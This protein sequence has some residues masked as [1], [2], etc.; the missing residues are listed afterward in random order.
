MDGASIL[1]VEDEAISALYIKNILTRLKYLVLDIVATGEN[2]IAKA[3]ALNPD[4]I[5]MDIRLAGEMDGIQAADI[6]HS[7]YDIPIVFLT[8]HLDEDSMRQAMATDPA[9]YVPKPTSERELRGTIEMALKNDVLKKQLRASEARYRRIFKTASVSISEIDFSQVKCALDGLRHEGITDLHAYMETN[10]NYIHRLFLYV[11]ILDA[12]D[13]NLQLF[14]A[15]DGKTLSSALKKLV[16]SES[17]LIFQELLHAIWKGDSYYEGEGTI[18]TL[19]G[20][21]KYITVNVAFLTGGIDL[22]RVLLIVT[23]ITQG[24]LAEAALR[25]SE[26]KYRRIVDTSQEGIW[27]LDENNLT[28]FVNAR[29]AEMFGYKFEEI[30][31]HPV[32]DF[33][34]PEEHADHKERMKIRKQGKA[35]RY[36]RCFRCKDGSELW[37]IISATPMFDAQ[38]KFIGSFA[39]FTDITER[40]KAEEQ[41]KF[42]A[43]VLDQNQDA[44]TVTDLDGCVTYVNDAA[45]RYL[46]YSRQVLIGQSVEEYGEDIT[47]GASQKEIIEKTIAEGEWRGEVVNYDTKGNATILDC[48]TRLVYDEQG[49]PIAMCGIS[50]D[51]TQ[52]KQIE[53]ALAESEARYRQIVETTQEGIWILDKDF[54]LTYVNNRIVELFGYSF[55]EIVGKHVDDFI[56]DEDMLDHRERMEARYLGKADQYERRLRRKDGRPIWVNISATPIFDDS[57]QFQGS[58]AMFTDI[59]ARKEADQVLEHQ[60]ARTRTMDALSQELAKLNLDFQATLQT[61]AKRIIELS[62]DICLIRLISDDGQFLQPVAIHHPD[63]DVSSYIR[64]V[65]TDYPIRIDEGLTEYVLN[66][67]HAVMISYDSTPEL[68]Q[69][70]KK[71]YQ[72]ILDKLNF[73]SGLFI[74]LIAQGHVIG[75]IILGRSIGQEPYTE[76]DQVFYQEVA[77]RIALTIAN[78]CMYSSAQKELEERRLIESAVRL[79][80]EKYRDL[81][82]IS[83]DS[84][85]LISPKGIILDC[86]LSTSKISGIPKEEMIG[87]PFYYVADLPPEKFPEYTEVFNRVMS[88]DQMDPFEIEATLPNGEKRNLEIYPKIV[89]KDEIITGVQVISRNITD[90]KLNEQKL[91]DSLAEK[92]TLLSELNHRVKN[93]LAS[94]VSILD[95]QKSYL[96]DVQMVDLITELQERIRLMALIH[97]QLYRSKNLNRVD[98]AKYLEDLTTN[99]A[100]ALLK[101]RDILLDIHSDAAQ[102]GVAIAIPCGQIVTELVTNALK[103]AFPDEKSDRW[104]DTNR[105]I[106]VCFKISGEQCTLK[107]GDNGIGLPPGL[108]FYNAETLGMQ[109]VMLLANQLNGTIEVNLHPGTTVCITFPC[110]PEKRKGKNIQG[111]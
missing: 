59:T 83:P 58:F 34:F 54:K 111:F 67:G 71:E 38:G 102:L 45:S 7:N 16:K 6:I 75:D 32:E 91:R 64:K 79:S 22:S 107:V 63:P 82:E 88:G 10:P 43:M 29:I 24:K 9:G 13:W 50:T 14:N 8:A 77:D 101:N 5:L 97:E 60:Q 44:V 11:H 28:S 4:L 47:R 61:A 62:G 68:Y 19:T 99:L 73:I 109:L 93:N 92:E 104:K 56:F 105:K 17:L 40:K 106:E 3:E 78:A 41:L 103:Y 37:V 110:P 84:I 51:I 18:R 85:T 2:A 70:I 49:K 23:D 98:F 48:R 76:E 30:I 42:Q 72:V 52:R 65:T 1:I 15:P 20:E 96:Y 87:K 55:E 66:V 80:E 90:R 39:M 81:F 31:G 94:I 46:K 89:K 69:L 27:I 57:G 100:R 21:K 12:N 74:P 25:E 108:D 95:L 86:N 36:E 26:E 33:L 35:E 53:K